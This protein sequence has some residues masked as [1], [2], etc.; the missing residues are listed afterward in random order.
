VS[1]ASEFDR[2]P[3]PGRTGVGSMPSLAVYS[4]DSDGARW[5]LIT[6]PLHRVLGGERPVRSGRVRRVL[7]GLVA[8][9]SV[10]GCALWAASTASDLLEGLLLLLLGGSAGALLGGFLV[11][12]LGGVPSPGLR[13]RTPDDGVQLRVRPSDERAWRLCEIGAALAESGSWAD[14]TVDPR[15]RAP[16]ILWSAVGRSLV[17]DRQYRDAQRAA[18]HESLGDLARET[19]ARVADERA[20]L[21]AVEANLRAVLAA[22]VRI[23]QQRAQRRSAHQ[24][25]R[26]EREL[27]ARLTGQHAAVRDPIESHLQ[28]D[29]SAGLAAEAEVVAELL[30]ES[31]AMLRDL[32]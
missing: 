3:S 21:D 25:R 26:E 9:G 15:R 8:Y 32:D 23:D 10:L 5:Y 14:A 16:A 29:S 13:R 12:L 28:A 19:L 24:R 4:A 22:A 7:V 17:V 2:S 20:A 1:S 6:D 30:A 11:V 31:D 27:R 18:A